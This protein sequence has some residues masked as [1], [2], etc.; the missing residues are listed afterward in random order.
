LSQFLLARIT[1]ERSVT[2][3]SAFKPNHSDRL[4]PAVA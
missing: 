4:P 1:M 3:K 2:P